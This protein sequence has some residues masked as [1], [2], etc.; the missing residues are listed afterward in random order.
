MITLHVNSD[1]C[2][3]SQKFSS[4]LLCSTN[5]AQFVTFYKITF[6]LERKPRDPLYTH[7]TR[8]KYDIETCITYLNA[9]FSCLL[10]FFYV[11]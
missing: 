8:R 11:Q 4:V 10:H 3:F 2:K 6:Q 1:S 7:D 5:L 9:I